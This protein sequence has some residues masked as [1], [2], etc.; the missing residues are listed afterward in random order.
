MN[1]SSGETSD[2]CGTL[3]H[4]F[5]RVRRSG[6]VRCRREATGDEVGLRRRYLLTG[7]ATA[8]TAAM[9]DIPGAPAAATPD[10]AVGS[11]AQPRSAPDPVQV[12]I[13]A[14]YDNNGIGV[15]AGDADLDGSGYG[16]PAADLP[17]G[18]IRVDD[19]PFDFP[20]TTTAGQH[21]NLVA[22]GQTIAIPAGRYQIAYLLV[23]STYGDT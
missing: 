22:M 5:L 20:V 10:A 19:V 11:G 18:R 16:F 14:G 3:A 8:V 4:R 9:L 1:L 2:V 21:D 7:A 15:A 23:T 17:S 12:P 13:S 6:R